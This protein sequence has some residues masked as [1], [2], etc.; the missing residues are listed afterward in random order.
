MRE[1]MA[2]IHQL[3]NF[4]LKASKAAPPRIMASAMAISLRKWAVS[5]RQP[6]ALKNKKATLKLCKQA[7]MC[8]CRG[9]SRSASLTVAELIPTMLAHDSK[10]RHA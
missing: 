6:Q 9:D 1:Y 3:A 10:S 8:V 7:S 5:L 4:C 2:G